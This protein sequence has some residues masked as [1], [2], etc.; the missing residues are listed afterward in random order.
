V[1]VKGEVQD[2]M[3]LT[4]RNASI[5]VDWGGFSR[6]ARDKAVFR[7]RFEAGSEVIMLRH[8]QDKGRLMAKG[9]YRVCVQEQCCFRADRGADDIALLADCDELPNQQQASEE[10]QLP[11]DDEA[12][13]EQTSNDDASGDDEASD[14]QASDDEASDEQASEERERLLTR[15]QQSCAINKRRYREDPVYREKK[16]QYQAEYRAKKKQERD[17]KKAREILASHGIA[18]S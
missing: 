12:S 2:R 18:L 8:V 3:A 11:G 7:A 9:T 15:R 4:K 16:K 1:D 17:L 14:E 10:E 6:S 13:D 5:V